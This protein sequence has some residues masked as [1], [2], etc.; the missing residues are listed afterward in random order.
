MISIKD[1][2]KSFPGKAHALDGVS[3]SFAPGKTTVIV[4]PSG[5][6][7]STLLRTL[8]LLEIPDEGHL[9]VED[10]EL[11]FPTKVSRAA[12]REPPPALGHGLPG[13]PPVPPPNS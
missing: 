12:K 4:G 7:K 6:G 9:Q 1:L 5:S 11:A 8:N 3:A 13:L 10:A 2:S